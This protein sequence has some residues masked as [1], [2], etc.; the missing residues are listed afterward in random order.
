MAGLCRR[1]VLVL[2]EQQETWICRACRWVWTLQA[3]MQQQALAS[4]S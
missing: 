4:V 2:Q 1:L 3:A